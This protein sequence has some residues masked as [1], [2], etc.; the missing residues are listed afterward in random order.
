MKLNCKARDLE[1]SEPLSKLKDLNLIKENDG[2][3]ARV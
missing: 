3:G 1:I 2:T